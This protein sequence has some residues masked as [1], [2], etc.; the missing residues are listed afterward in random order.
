MVQ[1]FRPRNLASEPVPETRGFESYRGGI[2]YSLIILFV[3]EVNHQLSQP[4]SSIY[5][6]C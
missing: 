6:Q 1:W 5:L 2:N 3:V 4:L